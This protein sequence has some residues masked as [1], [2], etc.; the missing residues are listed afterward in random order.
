LLVLAEKLRFLK[1]TR[2]LKKPGAFV[3]LILFAALLL[4]AGIFALTQESPDDIGRSGAVPDDYD[5]DD[6][7]PD[8]T[9]IEELPYVWTPPGPPRWFRSNAGGMALEET[10]SRL[11]A[12]RSQYALVIDYVAPDE[13][14]PRL[15]PYYQD[16][17]NVE[18]RILYEEGAETRRQWL[19]HDE[20]GITRVNAVFK[21]QPDMSPET[22]VIDQSANAPGE[23]QDTKETAEELGANADTDGE[24]NEETSVSADTDSVAEA[25]A[26]DDTAL[27]DMELDGAETENVELAGGTETE[28]E[29]VP[30]TQELPPADPMPDTDSPYV[31]ALIGETALSVGFIELY[32]EAAQII[33]DRWLFNDDSVI[34]IKYFYNGGLLLRAETSKMLSGSEFIAMYTDDYRYN[35]SYSLRRIERL[36][37]EETMPEPVRL[38]FPGRVLDAAADDNFFGEKLSV[39]TDFMGDIFTGEGFRMLYDTDNRGRILSQ[40]MIDKSDEIVWV[41]KNNWL[42]DRIVSSLKTE[43]EDVKLTEYEYDAGGDRIVQREIHNGV[44][45]RVVYTKGN[46]ETEELYMRGVLVLRAYWENGRKISEERVR[47]R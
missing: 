5:I 22:S 15:L 40:T 19:F 9:D 1:K 16:G 36:Y 26:G 4:F 30:A 27:T 41:I 38:T 43:G 33:E 24:E 20:S 12:L 47:R 25:N 39:I 34:M 46:K 28:T 35:R 17:Y 45:E 7:S 32:N 3:P 42:G 29:A 11:A 37:H 44:L 14:E 8:F 13:V 6:M 23:K 10:P 2:L 31:A 21:R 18:I